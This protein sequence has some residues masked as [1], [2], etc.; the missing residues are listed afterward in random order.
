MFKNF[1]FVFLL[2]LLSFTNGFSQTGYFDFGDL[3]TYLPGNQCYGVG[4]SINPM[5]KFN[6][7]IICFYR[8][9]YNYPINDYHYRNINKNLT[10][11]TPVQSVFSNNRNGWVF[12]YM[13]ND[14][15]YITAVY[16]SSGRDPMVFTKYNI[17]TDSMEPIGQKSWWPTSAFSDNKPLAFAQAPNGKFYLP[18]SWRYNGWN[19]PQEDI[20]MTISSDTMKTWTNWIGGG[21][22]IGEG[23]IYGTSSMVCDLNSNLYLCLNTTWGD[24]NV[25]LYVFDSSTETFTTKM[26]IDIG[27][28]SSIFINQNTGKLALIYIQD[29]KPVVKYSNIIDPNTWSSATIIDNTRT[30]AIDGFGNTSIGGV[31]DRQHSF[32]LW[33]SQTE[34]FVYKWDGNENWTNLGEVSKSLAENYDIGSKVLSDENGNPLFFQGYIDSSGARYVHVKKEFQSQSIDSGLVAYY[35]FNG[36]A[37]DESGNGN[38]GIVYGA[39][40]TFDKFGNPNSAYNF[41]GTAYI[42]IPYPTIDSRSFTFSTWLKT[43]N[44]SSVEAVQELFG[45]R[46]VGTHS[47]LHIAVEWLDGDSVYAQIEG[48]ASNNR[49]TVHS[50]TSVHDDQWHL[51]TVTS[52]SAYF[53]LYL[54]GQ[55][56]STDIQNSIGDL[57]DLAVLGG[58]F[59]D[60]QQVIYNFIGLMDEVRLYN[61]ALSNY[62]IQRLYANNLLPTWQMQIS[63]ETNSIFD[64]DN[65]AGA[66]ASAT[67]LFDSDFDIPEPAEPP[68]NYVQLYFPH[69]EWNNFLGDNFTQDIRSEYGFG[70]VAKKWDFEVRTD[71]IGSDITL[72]FTNMSIP[73]NYGITLFDVD[74]SSLYNLRDFSTFVYSADSLHRFRLSIGD[75]T[76]PIV[77]LL[78]PNGGEILLQNTICL[79]EWTAS[80][81]SGLLKYQL[82]YSTD[83]GATYNFIEEIPGHLF[84]Y[85]WTIPNVI[86]TQVLLKIT[87]ID[88]MYQESTDLSDG[89]FEISSGEHTYS[90]GW[91]LMS[92]PFVPENSSA[93]SVIGPY[94]SGYYYLYSYNQS[95]GYSTSNMVENGNGY[96]LATSNAIT[97]EVNGLLISDSAETDLSIGWNIIGDALMK[98]IPNNELKVSYVG[99]MVDFNTAVS[100]GWLLNSI[101]TIAAGDPGYSLA[102]TL[103]PWSGYWIC[104]LVEPLTIIYDNTVTESL[105]QPELV[106]GSKLDTTDYWTL[107]LNATSGTYADLISALGVRPDATDEFDFVYDNPEPPTLPNGQGIQ[108]YFNHDNWNQV[109]GSKYNFDYRT[110]LQLGESKEW[111]FE[112]RKNGYVEITWDTIKLGDHYFTLTDLDSTVTLNMLTHNFYRFTNSAQVRHFKIQVDRVTTSI[113]DQDNGVPRDFEISQNYPNPFNPTTTIKYGLPKKSEVTIELFNM[114]GQKVLS[115]VDEEKNAGYHSVSVDATNLASGVYLYR[116]QADQFIR[117]RKMLLIR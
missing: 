64:T 98:S 29:D 14:Y 49:S 94:T 38:N 79:I 106:V 102:D 96:W 27:Y 59:D 34:Q 28:G 65:F 5:I 20:Y 115:L 3:V 45:G 33:T 9:E 95:Y 47:I 4:N 91:N 89:L 58:Y 99:N 56:L 46:D 36:N 100:N 57:M 11:V 7:D 112:I 117:A 110:P 44:L 16:S 37:N 25:V 88:F 51:L 85:L 26:V 48:L 19:S 60:T 83:N 73:S 32:Y 6:S 61:R 86:S 80:D 10:A 69:P 70:D 104:T 75:T 105:F 78:T 74:N 41:D 15:I 84:S 109:L 24:S 63:A 54:D 18:I 93:D 23:D 13:K 97:M 113:S 17:N 81:N 77:E 87:A 35:P 42:D 103:N 1:M 39:A 108:L 62:E 76:S 40:L 66:A 30:G 31:Y 8:N 92:I 2:Y 111:F 114:L 107:N 116:I 71:Q 12:P 67:D 90:A 72:D 68:S 50:N 53:K 101:Y 52:D 55:L 22:I 21:H 82:E 43:S